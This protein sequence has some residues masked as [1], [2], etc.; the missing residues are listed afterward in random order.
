MK[1]KTK[2]HIARPPDTGAKSW[3]G[4]GETAICQARAA[5]EDLRSEEEFVAL[6]R[7]R[8]FTSAD[9]PFCPWCIRLVREFKLMDYHQPA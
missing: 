3:F 5:T 1:G 2:I 8:T 7:E 4:P 6:L 9:E